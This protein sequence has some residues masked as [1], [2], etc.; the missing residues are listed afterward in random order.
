[1]IDLMSTIHRQSQRTS[2]GRLKKKKRG[3]LIYTIC[4]CKINTFKD[5]VTLAGE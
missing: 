5:E 3:R 4:A 2:R 1:M